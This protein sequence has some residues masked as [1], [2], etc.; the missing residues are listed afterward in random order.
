MNRL[1]VSHFQIS[2]KTDK[3]LYRFCSFLS[4]R[5]PNENDISSN[6]AINDPTR[7]KAKCPS[8]VYASTATNV[9]LN[10]QYIESQ[11]NTTTKTVPHWQRW[12]CV[13]C[14]CYSTGSSTVLSLSRKRNANK[15][16]HKNHE[17]PTNDDQ[18]LVPWFGLQEGLIVQDCFLVGLTPT[19]SSS[20]FASVVLLNI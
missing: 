3:W 7:N 2:N 11:R 20:T 8:R 19:T 16:P 15:A 18:S 12:L 5:I 13:V 14:V 6:N 10:M 1:A 4:L 9:P 17:S